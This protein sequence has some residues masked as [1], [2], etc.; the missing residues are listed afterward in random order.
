VRGLIGFDECKIA[1]YDSYRE[2]DDLKYALDV[3]KETIQLYDEMYKGL[4]I[5][6]GSLTNENR[7]LKASRFRWKIFAITTTI[8]GFYVGTRL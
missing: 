2:R 6:N 4:L 1:L 7:K 3:E 5:E 8:I